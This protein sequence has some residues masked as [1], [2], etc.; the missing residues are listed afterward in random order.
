MN[1]GRKN[2]NTKQPKSV[3]NFNNVPVVSTPFDLIGKVA[4][5]FCD[6]EDDDVS[7][8]NWHKGIIL[9][10]FGRSKVKPH[11]IIQYEELPEETFVRDL[12]YDY[13]NGE[14]KLAEVDVNDFIGAS[15]KHLFID[16]ETG[17]EIWWEAEIVDV[18]DECENNLN[19]EFFVFY[20]DENGEEE[21]EEEGQEPEYF[22][23]KM[24]EE[25]LN[26]CVR[27]LGQRS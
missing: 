16:D 17:D 11:F 9:D 22:L 20:Y 23:E 2:T 3:T 12:F 6:F 8:H 25:Y 1:Q 7:E 13:K 14:L 27:F 10:T 21:E 19:P 26:G 15:V 4:S 5:H 24:I 18:D